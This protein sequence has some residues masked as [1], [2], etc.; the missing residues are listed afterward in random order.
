MRKVLLTVV[1]MVATALGWWWSARPTSL[2]ASP[3]ADAITPGV[4]PDPRWATLF[5]GLAREWGET[6]VPKTGGGAR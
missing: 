3:A 1:V 6:K 4:A 2:V 5:D